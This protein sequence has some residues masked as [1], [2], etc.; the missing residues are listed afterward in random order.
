MAILPD[1]LT[2]HQVDRETRRYEPGDEVAWFCELEE[3][4]SFDWPEDVFVELDVSVRRHG[5][6]GG[7][8]VLTTGS[9]DFTMDGDEYPADGGRLRAIVSEV[10]PDDVDVRVA[11]VRGV[12]RRIRVISRVR[13]RVELRE[14]D[15]VPR[16]PRDRD[17][18]PGDFGFVVD[19]ELR[20]G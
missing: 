20:A 6:G 19:L 9:A 18:G 13:R 8:A 14:A 5:R 2:A 3:A 7:T 10:H 12:I 4:R 17:P 15:S 1:F 11:P 16:T